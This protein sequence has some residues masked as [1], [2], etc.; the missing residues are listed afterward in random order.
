MSGHEAGSLA[1][2]VIGS[3]Q[4]GQPRTVA[5]K[6]CGSFVKLPFCPLW[7][8]AGLLNLLHERYSACAGNGPGRSL[9]RHLLTAAATPYCACLERWLRHGV[10]DDPY[11]EFMVQEDPVRNVT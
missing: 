10:L 6:F 11:H 1:M 4:S 2:R 9:L 8:P 5:W 3:Q 7:A